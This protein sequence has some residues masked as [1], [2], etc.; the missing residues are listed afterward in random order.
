M[1]NL[2][3]NGVSAHDQSLNQCEVPQYWGINFQAPD[4]SDSAPP[5]IGMDISQEKT[6]STACEDALSAI[7]AVA[8]A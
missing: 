4:A 3:A 1:L 7:G 6:E 5:F 2:C 8:G